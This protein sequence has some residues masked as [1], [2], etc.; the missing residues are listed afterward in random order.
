MRVPK[1]FLP[2]RLPNCPTLATDSM[3][4]T[5]PLGPLGSGSSLSGETSRARLRVRIAD[6]GSE[7][8]ASEWTR[9]AAL[10]NDEARDGEML[11]DALSTRLMELFRLNTSRAVFGLLYELNSQHLLIQVAGRLRRYASKADPRD[12]LQ[13]VFFNI[14]RYPNRFNPERDDA[15]RVWSALIVRNT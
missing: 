10:M 1:T 15:F 9:L 12:V 6:L 11:R 5:D 2:L 8:A 14:Y 7:V 13:E 3:Q 4:A